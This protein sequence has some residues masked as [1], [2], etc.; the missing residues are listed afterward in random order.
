MD[1]LKLTVFKN[2]LVSVAEEMGIVLQRTALSPNIKERKDLSCALFSKEGRLIAQAEHIPVHLGSMSTAVRSVL[3]RCDLEEGDVVILNDPFA[4]GTHLPD[5]TLVAPLHHRG[6]LLFVLAVRA[7]HSDVGGSSAGSMPISGEVF[8]EGLILPPIKLVRRGKL[9]RDLLEVIKANVRTPTE[10]E[11]DIKAQLMALE[12]GA[13]RL[14]ALLEE[15]GATT[16]VS[17]SEELVRYTKRFMRKRLSAMPDGEWF[18]EDFLEDDGREGRNIA[19]RALLRIE[20]DSATVD[21]SG[22]DPQSGGC[23]NCPRSVTLASV[24]YCFRCLLPEEVP[25]NDGCF[26]PIEVV[27]KKGTV[28][29]ADFPSAVSGGNVETSQRIVDVVLG[30]LHQALPDYIPSAS[31]GTMNNVAIGGVW[32]GRHWSYYETIGGGMGAWR[33]GDGES[34]VHSHMTNTMNTPVEA[35][36]HAYPLRITEYSIRKGS[37]GKG[38]KRGGDGIVRELLFLDEANLTVISERRRLSPYGLGGGSSGKSG[39]N[40]LK[41]NK[42]WK[43]MPSKFSTRIKKGYILRIETPGGG[44]HG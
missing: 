11:G 17:A 29:D 31:Q 4:G 27:T 40:L 16:V 10:R 3:S 5:I 9:N 36:E 35:L 26:E 22:S 25:T 24:F 2:K 20:G 41:D 7:H 18:F 43:E 21:L 15:L 12:V 30:A 28:V 32:E 37:G 34:G 8:Q 1:S 39:K 44:G 42:G 23:V 33:E 38:N 13:K 14:K 6:E 19:I